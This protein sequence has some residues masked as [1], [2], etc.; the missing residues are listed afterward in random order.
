MNDADT[1]FDTPENRR[2][3]RGYCRL[4]HR[5]YDNSTQLGEACANDLELYLDDDGA[6]IPD[7]LWEIALEFKEEA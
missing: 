5:E 1:K 2:R 3:V 7:F 6:T 4:H